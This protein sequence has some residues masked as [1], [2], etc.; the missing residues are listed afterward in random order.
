MK[1]K[2][3]V[4]KS[5][6]IWFMIHFFVDYIFGI[7]LLLFPEWTFS[8]FGIPFVETVSIRLIGAALIAIGGMSVIAVNW[9]RNS[10]HVLLSF[11]IFWSLAAVMALLISISET[12]MHFLWSFLVVF[13]VFSIVWIYY[14]IRLIE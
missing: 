6:K 2:M 10:Y 13:F 4:P 5:L 8:L 9:K 12:K 3:E 11:K 14:K 7:P 1:K